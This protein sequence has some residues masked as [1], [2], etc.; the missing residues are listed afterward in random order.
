MLCGRTL[1]GGQQRSSH[2]YSRL[3]RGSGGTSHPLDWPAGNGA[4]AGDDCW[5]VPPASVNDSSES[6]GHVHVG[7]GG[8]DLPGS[9]GGGRKEGGGDAV[10]GGDEEGAESTVDGIIGWTRV[11]KK[12][13]LP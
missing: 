2:F 1:G 6:A 9:E 13:Q 12:G 3:C 7:Q 11:G 8:L 4:D 5:T 10:G